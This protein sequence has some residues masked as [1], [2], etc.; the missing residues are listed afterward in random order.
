MSRI[1][2]FVVTD[3]NYREN[4]DFPVP[5]EQAENATFYHCKRHDYVYYPETVENAEGVRYCAGYYDE[6]GKFFAELILFHSIP[7]EGMECK[8]CDCRL[9]ESD[10]EEMKEFKCPKCDASLDY[11]SPAYAVQS[12]KVVL[13]EVAFTD[14]SEAQARRY[15]HEIDR[16]YDR[17]EMQRS[18]YDP[19]Y[20]KEK[21]R[22]LTPKEIALG[23]L[24]M[25][26]VVIL[27]LLQLAFVIIHIIVKIQQYF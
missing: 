5:V 17:V 26:V 1:F 2:D 11:L 9:H 13:T 19:G 25:A 7:K 27:M 22:K 18:Y 8:Y 21:P 12:D 3:E 10:I 15:I 6:T 23:R 24:K 14:K 4:T 20:Y 16:E